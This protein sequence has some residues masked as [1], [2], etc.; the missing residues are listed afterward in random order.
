M[1]IGFEPFIVRK[2]TLKELYKIIDL[3][4]CDMLRGPDAF[5]ESVE[6][7]VYFEHLLERE[8]E[9]MSL[10]V[11]ENQNGEILGWQSLVPCAADEVLKQYLGE[12]I[13]CVFHKFLIP[14]VGAS[15]LDRAVQ[16]GRKSNLLYLTSYV[17]SSNAALQQVAKEAGFRQVTDFEVRNSKLKVL[18]FLLFTHILY[19]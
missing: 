9:E 4:H 13:T 7:R 1:S 2:G 18:K 11:A 5:S 14:V 17:I 16:E 19:T 3:Y 8:Y 10:W 12:C 6:K 15:L